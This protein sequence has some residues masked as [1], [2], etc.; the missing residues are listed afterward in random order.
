MSPRNILI[1]FAL[2]MLAINCHSHPAEAQTLD[3]ETRAHSY[4]EEDAVIATCSSILLLVGKTEASSWFATIVSDEEVVD[5]LFD[6]LVLGLQ[7]DDFSIEE[8]EEASDSCI[9][10]MNATR[11]S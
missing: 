11:T 2:I 4:S 9:E 6:A 10:V 5:Y 1:Y 8:L 3:A 7:S